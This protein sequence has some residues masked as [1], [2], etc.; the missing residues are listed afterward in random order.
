MAINWFSKSYLHRPSLMDGTV[1]VGMI[2]KS[3]FHFPYPGIISK[4]REL[5]FSRGCL[6]AG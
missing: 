1:E 6:R 3:E 2:K 4:T 5:S